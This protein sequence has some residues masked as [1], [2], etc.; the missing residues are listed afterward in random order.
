MIR[1]LVTCRLLLVR[2]NMRTE[3]LTRMFTSIMKIYTRTGD[4]GSTGLFGGP[5]VDKA[6]ARIEAYGTVDELNA[7]IGMVRLQQL[8][9]ALNKSLHRIQNE[10]FSV[11]AELASPD[12]TKHGLQV[13]SERH[14]NRLEEWI[15]TIESKLP[16]L[17]HFILPGGCPAAGYLHFARAVCRRAE[18][19]VVAL[20]KASQANVSPELTHYLNRL[21]DF[22]FV[23]SRMANQQAGHQEVIWTN[24]DSGK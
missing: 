1:F 9:D 7:V 5:R 12:P 10:L 18:R 17:K 3:S 8:P 11:G 13:I 6:D 23:A 22:L 2:Y 14:I 20:S 16:P 4:D 15:D 24:P 19:C 21:S